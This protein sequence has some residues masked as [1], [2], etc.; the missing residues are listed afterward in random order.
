M[1]TFHR[2]IKYAVITVCALVLCR[3]VSMYPVYRETLQEYFGIGDRIWGFLLS[4]STGAGLIT[5]LIGGQLVDRWGPRRV[6]RVACVG[7]AT[8]FLGIAFCG[9]SWVLFVVSLGLY[10]MMIRPFVI[11]VSN[12][13]IQLFPARRRRMLSLNFAGTSAGGMLYPA[14]AEMLLGLSVSVPAVTFAMVFHGPFLVG[15]LVVLLV[16]LLYRQRKSLGS[17][18][19]GSDKPWEW[20]DLLIGPRCL[21]LVGLLVLHGTADTTI[22]LWMSRFLGSDVFSSQPI[23][24]G[25]VVASRAVAYLIARGLLAILPEDFGRRAFL[26]F[27]GILGGIIIIVGILSRNYLVMAGAYFLGAFIWSA[28]YPAMLGR[29]ADEETDKFGA[30]M[31]LQQ[32]LASGVIFLGLNGMGMLVEYV[33]EAAMWKAMLLPASAFPIIGIGGT[34]WIL[35]VGNASRHGAAR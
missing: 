30:A 33:G 3:M 27:P 22:T 6:I 24:P 7:V 26:V 10:G 1:K 2:R 12:Y 9:D 34:L 17:T 32:L 25:Y 28:E 35:F 4:I 16:S 8:A 14:V 20:R 13:L 5:V 23:G 21:P 31:A 11:A 19:R 29:L 18:D 15:A